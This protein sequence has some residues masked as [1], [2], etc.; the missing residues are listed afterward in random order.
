MCLRVCFQSSDMQ[1]SIYRISYPNARD[2]EAQVTALSGEAARGTPHPVFR[3]GN[4]GGPALHF[5]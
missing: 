3:W 4:R 2:Q 5:G 1:G